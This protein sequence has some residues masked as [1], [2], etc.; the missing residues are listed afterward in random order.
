MKLSETSINQLVVTELGQ[1]TDGARFSSKGV[2][3]TLNLPDGARKRI[4]GEWRHMSNPKRLAER[5]LMLQHAIY[6]EYP[7]YSGIPSVW[8]R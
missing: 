6:E 3:I 1:F 5:L 2:A 8:A 7:E 4:W